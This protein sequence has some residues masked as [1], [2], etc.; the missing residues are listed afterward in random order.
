MLFPVDTH[1]HRIARRLGLAPADADR[2]AVREALEAAVPEEKCG[3]GHTAMIQ[4]GREYCT[5]RAPACL[6][7]PDACPMADVCEQVGVY[8][9]TGEVVDPAE[10]PDVAESG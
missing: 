10:A 6:E 1:V 7:D 2:E 9:E 4:F 5:A 8:P 3:F